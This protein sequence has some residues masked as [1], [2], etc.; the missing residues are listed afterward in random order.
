MNHSL[1]F[2]TGRFPDDI[3]ITARNH[4]VAEEACLKCHADVT[5]MIRASRHR[6]DGLSCTVCHRNVGHGH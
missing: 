3:I 1:A 6:G 5:D 2:T 4:K